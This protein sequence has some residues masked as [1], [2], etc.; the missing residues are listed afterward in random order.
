MFH[1]LVTQTVT[2]PVSG[3]LSQGKTVNPTLK[4]TNTNQLR[5][6]QLQQQIIAQKKLTGQKLSI[7]QVA[8]KN[9]VPTQLIM[10]SKPLPSAMTVQQFQQ[11]IRS[12]LNVSSSPVVLA[13]GPPKI[14]PMNT[15]QGTKQTIQV[16][17]NIFFTLTNYSCLLCY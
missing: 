4:T 16:R 7:A 11:V 3:V 12:P 15:A 14:I 10:G 6:L 2:I 1:I 8:G 5:H 9:N 13:K 17:I